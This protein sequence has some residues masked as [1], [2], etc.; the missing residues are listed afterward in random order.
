M[1]RLPHCGLWLSFYRIAIPFLV[2]TFRISNPMNLKTEVHLSTHWPGK[3]IKKS[4][5]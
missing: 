3:S 5:D 1:A 2:L 4:E